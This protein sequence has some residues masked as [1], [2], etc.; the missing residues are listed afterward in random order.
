[1]IQA[2]KFIEDTQPFKLVK[3]D[4]GA[5]GKILYSLIEACRWYAWLIHPVMPETSKKVLAQLGLSVEQ[6]LAK[7]WDAALVWGG[8]QPGAPLGERTPLFPRLTEREQG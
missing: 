5:V 6:E 3:T 8:L 7:G 1:M 2:N 4:P